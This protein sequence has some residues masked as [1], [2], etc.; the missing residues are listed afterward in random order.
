MR[1]IKNR[2]IAF[3]TDGIQAAVKKPV[4]FAQQC[5]RHTGFLLVT[6]RLG[7]CSA[8]CVNSINPAECARLACL[9]IRGLAKQQNR[10]CIHEDKKKILTEKL[11]RANLIIN[12]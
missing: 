8:L 10:D 11:E 5:A 3:K 9:A 2:L 6:A 1:T 7:L 12:Y 4:C